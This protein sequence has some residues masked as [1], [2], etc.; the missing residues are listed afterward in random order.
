MRLIGVTLGRW[1][2][3]HTVE[4]GLHNAHVPECTR[5][6]CSVENQSDLLDLDRI[7]FFRCCTSEFL[8][9]IL[10]LT[11]GVICVS[12]QLLGRTR[13]VCGWGSTGNGGVVS[14]PTDISYWSGLV[15]DALREILEE[16]PTFRALPTAG[17]TSSGHGGRDPGSVALMASSRPAAPD[18]RESHLWHCRAGKLSWVYEFRGSVQTAQFVYPL[19]KDRSRGLNFWRARICIPQKLNL[20]K[21]FLPYGSQ[22]IVSPGSMVT[23]GDSGNLRGVCHYNSEIAYTQLWIITVD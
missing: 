18:G 13:D 12:E 7:F 22:H 16:I 15:K 11:I 8:T 6:V 9:I 1:E 19:G 14:Y 3:P 10:F 20:S 23:R 2:M 21:V 17:A 4:S 5:V